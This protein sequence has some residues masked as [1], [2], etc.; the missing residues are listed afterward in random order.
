LLGGRLTRAFPQATVYLLGI[1]N[2]TVLLLAITGLFIVIY[3]VLPD[4][5]ISWRDA[6]VGSI[7]TALLFMAGKY[8]IGIYL[9]KAGLG[10]TYGTAAS[11]VVILTWVYYS[12]VILYFGAEFTRAFAL[13]TGHG[14][15]PKTTAV[16]ILKQESKEIPN[17]RMEL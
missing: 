16:F 17:S 5:I 8:L 7:F 4:A 14:I 11:I 10:I 2:L 15:R 6:L 9:G 13:E 1:L 12:S 3:K